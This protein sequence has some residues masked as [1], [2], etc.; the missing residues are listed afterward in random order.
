MSVKIGKI[1]G[2][3]IELNYSWFLIFFLI[4]WSLANGYLPIEYPHQS[5]SFYW[6]VGAASA[7]FLY[8]SILIHELAHSAIALRSGIGIKNI[9]LHF[10]GGVSQIQEESSDPRTEATMAIVGP[11]SS[12][13]IGVSLLTIDYLLGPGLPDIIEALL[14]YGGFVNVALAIFNLIP[15]FPMDGGR[16]LRAIFWSRSNNLI[17]ATRIAS[18]I[19]NIISIIFMLLGFLALFSLGTLDGLWLVFIGLFINGASKMGLSQTIISEAL[20]ERT[21]ESIM[22]KD[23]KTLDP[24]ISLKQAVKEWFSVYKHQGYPVVEND[25]VIGL[26]AISDVRDVTSEERETVKVRDVMKK[27]DELHTV[28]PDDKASDALMKMATKNVGRLPVIE[29]GK[30]V[31]IISRSDISRTIQMNTELEQ[32]LSILLGSV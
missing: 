14:R 15:A 11:I 22:T 6:F 19:S 23:V 29:N 2:I 8:V 5:S 1:H 27:K 10:F 26:I 9:T 18:G 16:V 25:D 4:T 3:S 21:V 30:L 20:G 32:H 7:L 13:V 31:G 24:D 17:K 28:S 12:I